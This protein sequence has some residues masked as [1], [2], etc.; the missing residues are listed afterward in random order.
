MIAW[1]KK[2]LGRGS[3]VDLLVR[4]LPNP[5]R[6]RAGALAW[7]QTVKDIGD[8]AGRWEPEDSLLVDSLRQL[9]DAADLLGPMVDSAVGAEKRIALVQQLRLVATSLGVADAA[10]DAF[11]D[12]KGAPILERYIERLRAPEG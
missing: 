2:W 5:P 3:K 12:T 4:A 10:F 6:V 11:W 7:A 1:F 8:R 9:A